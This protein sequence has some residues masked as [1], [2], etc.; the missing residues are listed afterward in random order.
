[1]KALDSPYQSRKDRSSPEMD[2]EEPLEPG[3][4]FN[5]LV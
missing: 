5:L 2:E 3:R 4:V 1:M